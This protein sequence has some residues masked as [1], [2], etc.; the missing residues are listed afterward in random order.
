MT[1]DVIGGRSLVY[2]MAY[3]YSCRT[4]SH[5][6]KLIPFFNNRQKFGRKIPRAYLYLHDNYTSQAPLYSPTAA[7]L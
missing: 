2:E 3:Y 6:V 1:R 4:S 7:K 5:R